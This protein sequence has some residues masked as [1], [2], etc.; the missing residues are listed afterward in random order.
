MPARIDFQPDLELQMFGIM[1]RQ[2]RKK[3]GITQDQLAEKVG[4][5]VGY[6]GAIERKREQRP[7]FDVACKLCKVLNI[8][9]DRLLFPTEDVEHL[10]AKQ[11]LK[12]KIDQCDK[13]EIGM[14]EVLFSSMIA[15]HRFFE[16]PQAE[17]EKEKIASNE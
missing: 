3:M 15:Y 1:V 7:S 11:S 9:M 2:A 6:L 13:Y 5:S 10:D 12:R 8:S 17:K 4:I 16:T 14:L